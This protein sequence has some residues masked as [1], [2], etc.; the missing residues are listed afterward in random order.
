[1]ARLRRPWAR[2]SYLASTHRSKWLLVNLS[3]TKMRAYAH[4][5]HGPRAGKQAGYISDLR[6]YEH[7][8]LRNAAGP[9]SWALRKL[10]GKSAL[11]GSSLNN[12]HQRLDPPRPKSANK[13]DARWSN[14]REVSGVIGRR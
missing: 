3:E 13:R 10:V 9:Y 11:V 7:S 5:G 4:Q 2:C 1:M 6:F 8:L 12:G 14:R